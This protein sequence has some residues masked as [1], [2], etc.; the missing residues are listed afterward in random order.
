MSRPSLK[1]V[2]ADCYWVG[3]ITDYTYGNSTIVN[4]TNIGTVNGSGSY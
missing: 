2:S 3:G 1:A 4:C